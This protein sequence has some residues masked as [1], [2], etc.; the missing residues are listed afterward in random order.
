[1]HISIGGNED[2]E[3]VLPLHGV[4]GK[5]LESNNLD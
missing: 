1:L 5:S 4:R 3:I 2:N